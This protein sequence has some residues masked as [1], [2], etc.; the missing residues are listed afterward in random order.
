MAFSGRSGRTPAIQREKQSQVGP[1]RDRV[2]P[3]WNDSHRIDAKC[4]KNVSFN[5]ILKLTSLSP[6]YDSRKQKLLLSL[7]GLFLFIIYL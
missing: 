4:P 2:V 3:S 7:H 1:I 6:I 5:T